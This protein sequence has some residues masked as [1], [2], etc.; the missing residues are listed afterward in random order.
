M[1]NGVEGEWVERGYKTVRGTQAHAWEEERHGGG[2]DDD[3]D[4]EEE[5]EEEDARAA[6]N[7]A[8]LETTRTG[9]VDGSAHALANSAAT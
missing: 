7:S 8:M 9:V 6:Q 5:D 3:D 2:E 1:V 4:D